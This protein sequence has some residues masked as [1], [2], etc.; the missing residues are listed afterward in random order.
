VS[1][2]AAHC[3]AKFKELFGEAEVNLSAPGRAN[4]I[5]EHTDY[6]QGFVLPFAINKYIHFVA[7]KSNSKLSSI[8]SAN[9]RESIQL[10]KNESYHG[11]AKFLNGCLRLLEKNFAGDLSVDLVF[12]GDL[13]IGAGMSS[14]SALCCGFLQTVSKLYDLNLSAS[15]LLKMAITVERGAGVDGGIMDQFT[16]INGKKD[17][18]ILLDCLDNS[19]VY[20]PFNFD[21]YSFVIFD[22]GVE[23][24]LADTA[25]N[26]RVRTCRSALINI[27]KQDS[28]VDSYRALRIE[29]LEKLEGVERK[30][31]EHVI[32][33][34][35]RLL[36]AV[37]ALKTKDIVSLGEL[38][39]ESHKSL[40]DL[41]EVSCDELNFIANFLQRQDHV[42]GARMMGGGF[43]GS[44][45]ALVKHP[46]VDKIAADLSELYKAKF[47]IE[48]K[49]FQIEP[50]NGIMEN[51]NQ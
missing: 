25:Y 22:T 28:N 29:H 21:N 20:I 50:S 24:N 16:I 43:G 10:E 35:Q 46:H 6:N 44:V 19:K 2:T 17:H 34:N 31:I 3:S 33:E 27:Q 45:I 13:P 38:L 14:S 15:Q 7:R 40:R 9:L 30:R 49:F 12:G 26:D 47:S 5:G 4:I 41:Y 32:L 37:Y 8:Y 39:N 51:R 48:L 36:S 23:H 11:F 42:A 18:A 1:I